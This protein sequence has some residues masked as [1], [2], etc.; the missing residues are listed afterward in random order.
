ML[1]RP[2]PYSSL[3]I[4]SG[5]FIYYVTDLAALLQWKLFHLLFFSKIA[6]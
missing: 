4:N 5:E 3:E 1:L 2:R 6:I